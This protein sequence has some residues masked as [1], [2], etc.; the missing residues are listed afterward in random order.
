M[1]GW[2]ITVFV[3]NGVLYFT[4]KKGKTYSK[5]CIVLFK[6]KN[7][8]YKSE[9]K[10][11][12]LSLRHVVRSSTEDRVVQQHAQWKGWERTTKTQPIPPQ[13]YN[14]Q[15]CSQSI[16][17]Q[18]YNTQICSQ[19]IPPQRYNTQICS[20]SIPP[21]IYNTQICSQPI[22]PQIYN[23]QICSQLIPPQ[24]YITQIC[25]KPIPPQMYKTQI[26]SQPIPPQIYNTQIWSQLI[27]PQI[28]CITPRSAP[29]A[30]ISH[31]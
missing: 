22:P 1:R 31:Y 7:Y 3:F 4:L 19:L 11:V 14:S 9:L 8:F 28:Y 26:C 29:K 21:Q 25:S 18:M 10:S 2:Y 5:H 6:V 12:C 24:I 27:P 23:T 15:I 20:Q 13:I 16:P 17:P 30:F